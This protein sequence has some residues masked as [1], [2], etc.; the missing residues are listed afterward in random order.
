MASPNQKSALNIV[1]GAMTFGEEGKEGARVHKLEDVEAILDVFQAHGHTE[2]DTARTYTGGTSEEYLGKIDWKKRGLILETKL[3]PNVSN[4]RLQNPDRELISHKPEDLRKHLERSLKALNTDQLE[5]WYLHGPDR[6]TPIGLTLRAVNELYKE[7]KFKRFGISNY[8]AWEVAE[9]VQI[10]RGNG[11]IQPTAYQGIYNA[12]HRK[13]EPEL[14]PCLRKFGIAFYEFNPLGG[15][16][17]TG[18]Y[19]SL[20]DK[21]EPGSRFDPEKGQG[22]SYRA[23]YWNEPYFKAL[24]SIEEIAKEH[25]LTL[26]E[27]ALRWISHHSLMKREYGDAVIIGA[28]SVKHI[29]ENLV[30]LEKGPLPDAVV[31][32]LDDTWFSVAPYATNYFH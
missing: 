2:I 10:C 8:M 15:G 17:F 24:A 3:Y 22:R 27:I 19:R 5:M 32:A 13:V 4:T 26:A 14:F 23:R 31:K 25:N 7:G 16:F 6:T 1:M 21:V 18:R 20:E 30:D 11:Y 29:E 28:S 12:V 9:I